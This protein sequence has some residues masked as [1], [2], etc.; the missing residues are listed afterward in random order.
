MTKLFQDTVQYCMI[1]TRI[2]DAMALSPLIED[3]K[4]KELDQALTDWFQSFSAQDTATPG[5]GRLIPHRH[6]LRWRYCLSRIILHRPMLLW[7][8]MRGLKPRALRPEQKLAIET[9]REAADELITDIAT[10][11]RTQ[12]ACQFLGTHATWILYQAVMVPLLSLFSDYL[13][14]NIVAACRQQVEVAKSALSDLHS[15]SPIGKQSLE[16]VNL[17]YAASLR[18]SAQK[19]SR[20]HLR[21]SQIHQSAPTVELCAHGEG[22]DDQA[23]LNL[24]VHTALDTPV[25]EESIDSNGLIDLNWGTSWDSIDYMLDMQDLDWRPM[26]IPPDTEGDRVNL[27]ARTSP[28]ASGLWQ[29]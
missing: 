5:S 20:G 2:E 11:W 22:V 28:P 9:C 3:T 13:D 26:S 7:Y 24:D 23:Q 29:I 15:W 18:F 12:K 6:V 16:S 4:C 19:C 8:A 14:S 25:Q 21:T 27:S 1:S 17:I 10:T